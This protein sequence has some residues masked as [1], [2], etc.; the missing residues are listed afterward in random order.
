MRSVAIVTLRRLRVAQL[1]NFAVVR[2]EVR[3]GDRFVAATALRHDLQ[4]EPRCI[5]PPNRVRCM[6]IT[7]YWQRFVRLSDLLGVDA[8]FELLFDSMVTPSTR[9]GHIARI[10]ARECVALRKHAVRCVTV[11]ARGSHRQSALH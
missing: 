2:V 1:G 4:F 11:S 3:L 8:R 5:N 7:A 10:H 6:A 9:L